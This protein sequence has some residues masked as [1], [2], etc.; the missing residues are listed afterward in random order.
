MKT[1][2]R[3]VLM[4]GAATVFVAC[5]GSQPPIGAPGAVPQTSALAARTDSTNYKVV[6]SFGGG[7]DGSNPYAGLIDVGGTL[8]GTTFAGGSYP[9]DFSKT[10][11][12]GTVFSVTLGGT[13]NVLHSFGAHGDGRN[14]RAGLIDVGGTLYGTTEHGHYACYYY[15]G[16]CGTVFSITPSG[17]E[18]VLVSFDGQPEGAYPFAGLI[19]VKGTLYGTTET[20]GSGVCYSNYASCGT[21]FSLR[22][23]GHS[24]VLYSFNAHHDGA[25][26]Y[27]GLIDVK[28]ELYGT[29][30]KGGAND[31]GAVFSV[32]LG[33]KEKVRHT[34]GAA[35]D[36][37]QP[38]A[39][40]IDVNGK[41][42]GTTLRGARIAAA[43]PIRAVGPSLASRRAARK[44]Y[45]TASVTELMV[46]T[47][48]RP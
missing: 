36:G 23:G 41:L 5:G 25:Y 31:L 34:F 6:Y 8:Y 46:L 4:V 33:G 26:P 29:T 20:G 15:Y 21:V 11:G 42:Y 37:A 43:P 14:P 39:G 7:S 19:D 47:P 18:K 45:S 30:F 3:Y 40:L 48:T 24:G 17:A 2:A 13:E 32:T 1:L 16:T 28:G 27:A 38:S 44:P 35:A 12:C 10:S 9:C 22:T